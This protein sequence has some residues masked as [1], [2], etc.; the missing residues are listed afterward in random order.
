VADNSQ[1][2]RDETQGK[3]GWT[4]SFQFEELDLTG[5]RSRS[6]DLSS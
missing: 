2:V 1:L 5:W 6:L 4:R 3:G